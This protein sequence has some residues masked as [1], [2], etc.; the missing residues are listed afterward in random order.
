M[1]LKTLKQ[2]ML[3]S[4]LKGILSGIAFLLT[5]FSL[6]AQQPKPGARSGVRPL[7]VVP[8]DI[9]EKLVQL[10]MQ[11]P[12]FEISERQVSVAGLELRKSKQ[13]IL[14]NVAIQGNLNEFSL[15]NNGLTA[16][17]YPRYNIGVTVPLD[18]FLTR[19]NDIKIARQ[20]LGIAQASK[21]Q[22]FREIKALVLTSYEGY[23][24]HLQKLVFQNQLTEDASTIFKQKEKDF[25][26]GIIDEELYNRAY[27]VWTEEQSRKVEF[28][29][30]VNVSKIEL[31]RFI[32]VPLDSVLPKK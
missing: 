30:D 9:R 10:A 29:H 12:E 17:L 8:A 27:R 4:T 31:E 28:Q 18:L 3:R 20:N 26:E 21:N 22:Q 15:K 1:T 6:Q 13:K 11:N 16:S 2:I 24:M 5:A 23:L 25:S 14:G 19:S 32:G 7:I